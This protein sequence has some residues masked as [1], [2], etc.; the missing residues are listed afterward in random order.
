MFIVMNT[1]A[2]D[3][4]LLSSI[5][6]IYFFTWCTYWWQHVPTHCR[7]QVRVSEVA[8]Q[9]VL[10]LGI[11]YWKNTQSSFLE[12]Y[13]VY[14]HTPNRVF[15]VIIFCLIDNQRSLYQ[16]VSLLRPHLSSSPVSA[17][18]QWAPPLLKKKACVK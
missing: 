16:L 11:K 18:S 12:K 17:L 4:Q 15:R 5:K 8:A 13:N 7:R 14:H 10:N 3:S 2:M 6:V 9:L 1:L